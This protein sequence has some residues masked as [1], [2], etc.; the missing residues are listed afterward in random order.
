[1]LVTVF[2]L[3]VSSYLHL[4]PLS[5]RNPWVYFL[6]HGEGIPLFEEGGYQATCTIREQSWNFPLTLVMGALICAIAVITLLDV[7]RP[8]AQVPMALSQSSAVCA[9]HKLP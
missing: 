6:P 4:L 9:G 2:L 8:V 5:H 7:W 3:D 1:M